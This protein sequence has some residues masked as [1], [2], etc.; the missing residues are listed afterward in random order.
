MNSKEI[1]LAS[2]ETKI[3]LIRG[4][5]VMLDQDLAVLYAVSTKRLNER[6]RRNLE[7]FPADF[8]FLLLNQ[9][10]V[11]L[12]S[13]FATSSLDWGGRRY[14]PMVFTEQGITMLSSVL[15]SEQAI[16]VN[17]AIMRAFVKMRSVLNTNQNLERKLSALEAKYDGSFRLVFNAIKEL[18]SDHQV[19]RKRVIGLNK[20]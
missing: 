12:R 18:M 4:E 7:R 2:I 20:P 5:K 16:E 14:P 11:N 8:M 17:I 10:L 19:P 13:Q 3:Y 9:E 1:A 15:R 6:V